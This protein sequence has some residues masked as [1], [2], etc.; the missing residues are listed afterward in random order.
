LCGF[1]SSKVYNLIFVY[2]RT[3]RNKPPIPAAAPVESEPTRGKKIWG[4]SVWLFFHSFAE[5]IKPEY[6]STTGKEFIAHIVNICNNLPC[7]ECA[8]HASAYMQKI[9]LNSIQTKDDLIKMLYVFHNQVNKRVGQ[10]EFEISDLNEKYNTANLVNVY[11]NFIRHFSD[12]HYSIRM[13]SDDMFRQR[14]CKQLTVWLRS[15]IIHFDA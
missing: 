12:K 7:P 15:N 8:M 14:L 6:F 2:Y 11:N 3:T 5:K 1:K 9:Q 4:P 10:P 13:I